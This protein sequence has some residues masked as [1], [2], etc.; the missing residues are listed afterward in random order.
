MVE[1][2]QGAWSGWTNY[3]D[4]G[5]LPALLLAVLLYL[6][7]GRRQKAHRELLVYTSVMAVCCILPV[8]AGLLMMYQTKFYNYEWIWSLVPTTAV[9]AYGV[10]LFWTEY[11]AEWAGQWKKVLPVAVL[12]TSVFLFCGCMGG[13][14]WDRNGQ[15]NDR[16]RAYA[17]LEQVS[18]RHPGA[19][20]CLWAPREVM[21]YAREKDASIRLPYGRNIWDGFLGAYA[22][23]IYDDDTVMLER[24]MGHVSMTGVADLEM[25]TKPSVSSLNGMESATLEECVEKARSKGVNCILLTMKASSDAVSRMEAVLETEAER[26]EAYYLFYVGEEEIYGRTD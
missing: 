19:E 2:M 13:Q 10:S 25:E 4:N 7:F 9:V 24:W 5:K 3:T 12:L 8:T 20:I 23:D 15:K 1:W 21:E 11:R 6:W 17:A 18:D 22:Y 26:L 14:D 16:A